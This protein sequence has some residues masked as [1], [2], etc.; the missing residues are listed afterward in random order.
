MHRARIACPARMLRR[1][2]HGR[3]LAP[4]GLGANGVPF[5]LCDALGV[6]QTEGVME[7]QSSVPADDPVPSE[8]MVSWCS[9]DIPLRI[10]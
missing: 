3:A 2:R 7:E 4:P 8:A 1:R 10:V 5:P 9:L 6:S